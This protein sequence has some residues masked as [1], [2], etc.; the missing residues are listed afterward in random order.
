M[1]I[2]N[3]WKNYLV[4]EDDA[5]WNKFETGYPI[6]EK[7]VS[8]PFDVI[9]LGTVYANYNKDTFKLNSGQSGT[10]YIV[11]NDYYATLYRNLTESL[12]GFVNTGHYAQYALD[13]Y[14]KR[15]QPVDKWFCVIP[16][17]MIQRE[18]YSDIEKYH[19]NNGLYFS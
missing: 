3:G 19:L 13:Q 7:L 6:L 11:S 8:N 2:D 14:W 1:A 10:A 9:L 17:L 5:I 16:S 12:V 4:V 18:G 15:L